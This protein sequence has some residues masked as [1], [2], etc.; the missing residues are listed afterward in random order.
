MTL[1]RTLIA[2]VAS[3]SLFP[4]CG[5]VENRV[6]NYLDNQIGTECDP[7]DVKQGQQDGADGAYDWLEAYNYSCDAKPIHGVRMDPEFT[8]YD[9]AY[10]IGFETT[11]SEA[12]GNA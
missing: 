7:E 11:W 12:C 8:S 1:P 5:F 9:E 10:I 3:I 4:G 6:E 2:L